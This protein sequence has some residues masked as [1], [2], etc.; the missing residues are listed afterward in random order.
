MGRAHWRV[1]KWVP[2]SAIDCFR[3]LGQSTHAK[4]Y[5]MP[6]ALRGCPL[7]ERNDSPCFHEVLFFLPGR[8]GL[9]DRE[10]RRYAN[11]F[12]ELASRDPVV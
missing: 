10:F 1:R 2:L 12:S 7:R 3:S 6:Y 11:S 9:H 5:L 4:P 8:G